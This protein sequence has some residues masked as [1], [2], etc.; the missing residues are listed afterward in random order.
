MATVDNLKGYAIAVGALAVIDMISIAVVI[1][2]KDVNI[3]GTANCTATPTANACQINDTADA[4][5]T[6][7]TIF[8]TFVGVIILALI[9]K[10]IIG[11]YKD[12]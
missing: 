5:V 2:Y 10:V 9:G 4:F 7:L 11:L 12:Q 6:G 1:G 3:F 8:A